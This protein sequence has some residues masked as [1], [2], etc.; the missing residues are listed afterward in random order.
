MGQKK[1]KKKGNGPESEFRV[2]GS[3]FVVLDGKACHVTLVEET[4]S[5]QW[6][7]R[8]KDGTLHDVAVALLATSRVEARQKHTDAI[9][10]KALDGVELPAVPPLPE[11]PLLVARELDVASQ[12][13]VARADEPA[14]LVIVGEPLVDPVL[15]GLQLQHA[16]GMS[17]RISVVNIP[18]RDLVPQRRV[19]PQDGPSSIVYRHIGAKPEAAWGWKPPEEP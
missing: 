5:G 16:L 4:T 12:P 7:V 8:D 14:V 18:V 19:P 17:R 11:E 2:G 10:E 3:W 1:S 6:V 15:R 13:V 9:V